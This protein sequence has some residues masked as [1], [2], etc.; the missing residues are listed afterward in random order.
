[1]KKNQNK[2]LV[3]L[4]LLASMLLGQVPKA[5]AA[6]MITGTNHW[7]G[8]DWGFWVEYDM[9]SVALC[10]VLL[11]FCLL[12]NKIASTDTANG[13]SLRIRRLSSQY[14]E[15]QEIRQIEADQA[16]MTKLLSERRE[17][18]EPSRLYIG[19]SDTRKSI[20]QDIRRVY[21]QASDVYVEFITEFGG[22]KK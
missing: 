18:N 15:A 10:I 4:G 12:D 11:P 19:K 21:P 20:A 2:K 9:G 17:R 1:M 7:L 5:D 22:L 6:L 3:T 16:Q 8:D 13:E 14:F